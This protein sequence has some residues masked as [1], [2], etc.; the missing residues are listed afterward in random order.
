MQIPVEGTSLPETTTDIITRP[1]LLL[2]VT[3]EFDG[4]DPLGRSRG[5]T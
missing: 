5:T 4:L 2:H 1:E 3:D